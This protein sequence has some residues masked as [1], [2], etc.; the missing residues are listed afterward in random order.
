[1]T[2]TDD[3]RQPLWR[4]S[5]Q[6]RAAQDERFDFGLACVLDGVAA[7]VRSTA[8]PAKNTN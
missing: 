2:D 5:V 8:R 7:R 3:H 1:V 4:F 6:G